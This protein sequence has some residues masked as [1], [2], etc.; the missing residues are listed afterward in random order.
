MVISRQLFWFVQCKA[1]NVKFNGIAVENFVSSSNMIT[2][3][4]LKCPQV[5]LYILLFRLASIRLWEEIFVIRTN[6]S[7]QFHI[8]IH[9]LCSKIKY[10]LAV[11]NRFWIYRS[12]N[13]QNGTAAIRVCDSDVP[14]IVVKPYFWLTCRQCDMK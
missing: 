11:K 3:D 6:Y 14:F 12:E 10:I 13:Y 9:W 4:E 1:T 8:L 7:E 2:I 5:V